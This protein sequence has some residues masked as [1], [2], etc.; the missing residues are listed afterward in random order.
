MSDIVQRIA[1]K[2]LITNDNN[3][4]LVLREAA[5]YKEGTNIGRY[6]LPGGRLNPGEAWQ[7]GLH[8][9]VMEETG[10]EV[11]IIKPHYVGEWRPIMNGISH[12][13]IAVFMVCMTKSAKPLLSEE[14]DDYQW[15]SKENWTNFDIMQPDSLISFFNQQ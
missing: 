1:F 15:V 5:T 3:E 2:A 9:E 10:M 6:E 4:V 8:R 11:E 13:I 7:D 14:H 12:Q